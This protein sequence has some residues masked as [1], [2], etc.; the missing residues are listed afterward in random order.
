M[1]LVKL[2]RNMF[3]SVLKT[4]LGSSV[5]E[6]FGMLPPFSDTQ[7]LLSLK[8]TST[9]APNFHEIEQEQGS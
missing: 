1:A 7:K 4:Q 2:E 8:T 9:S 5:H 6:K 3:F